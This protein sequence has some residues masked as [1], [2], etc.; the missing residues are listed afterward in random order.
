MLL[1]FLFLNIS[2]KKL[3]FY[4]HQIS[5]KP[6]GKVVVSFSMWCLS[7]IKGE[8]SGSHCWGKACHNISESLILFLQQQHLDLFKGTASLLNEK[9]GILGSANS[10]LHCLSDRQTGKLKCSSHFPLIICECWDDQKT[11]LPCKLR[12][13]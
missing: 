9:T 2:L 8:E 3:K 12:N 6:T 1:V 5:T 7:N 11:R 13:A 10:G 4:L